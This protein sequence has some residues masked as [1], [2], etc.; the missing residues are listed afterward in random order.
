VVTQTAKATGRGQKILSTAV[1]ELAK[2]QELSLIETDNVNTD[3][4]VA[5]LRSIRPDLI[6]V[7]AFGQLLKEG[8]LTLPKFACLNVHASL[9]PK[10]RGAAPVQWA[11]WKGDAETG[12]TI[13]KMVKKLDAGDILVQ[14]RTP[15]L[16][17]ETSGQLL[18]RLETIGGEA[19]LEA[20]RLF[21]SGRP[22]FVTQ[23]ELQ[24]T[25]ARKIEKDDAVLNWELPA[26]ELHNQIRALQP[27]PVAETWLGNTRLKI[28]GTRVIPS[29]GLAPGTLQTDL[30]S[31]VH[32]GCGEG[33][34]AL[35][36]VQLDN[37][38]RVEIAGFLQG[39]QGSFPYTMVGR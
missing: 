11:I 35:T 34:L 1:A 19:L 17:N 38:K 32:V 15:I 6:L 7:V 3:E 18:Q 5:A 37:R 29:E 2:E 12:V 22:H 33:G 30:K 14:K 21:E 20:I 36:E 9:L 23:D 39:F 25:Y 4:V 13:Q 10:Y 24:A 27:W 8:V 28:Y 26:T 31:F 16:P